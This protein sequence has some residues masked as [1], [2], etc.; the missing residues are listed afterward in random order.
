MTSTKEKTRW[1]VY[2]DL[3]MGIIHQSTIGTLMGVCAYR[4]VMYKQHGPMP[5][6]I[7]AHVGSGIHAGAEHNYKQK[8][9]SHADL[10]VT[11][12]EEV[13]VG[14]YHQK[15]KDE[16]VTLSSEEKKQ[17]KTLLAQGE[18]KVRTLAETYTAELAPAIQPDLV[19]H[20]FVVPI[21]QID[22]ALKGKIDLRDDKCWLLD[23]KTAGQKKS[24]GDVDNSD[25]LPCYAFAHECLFGVEPTGL[26]I[27]V[28][29]CTD[30]TMKCYR[31]DRLV[32]TWR[33]LHDGE[34]E[35]DRRKRVMRHYDAFLNRIKLILKMLKTGLFPPN[36]QS[37]LCSERYCGYWAVCEWPYK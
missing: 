16:G 31:Q 36:P 22:I 37:F 17:K 11:E 2:S 19:E 18:K 8:R 30:K 10:A 12:I 25:Q 26:G 33:E 35:E 4:W 23:L 21:P 32:A 27:D 6:G 7:A 1:D 9:E 34:N 14:T 5:P 28:L 20:E 13:A 24:Q 29:V 3:N 15:L